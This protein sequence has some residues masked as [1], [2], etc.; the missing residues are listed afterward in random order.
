MIANRRYAFPGLLA[1]LGLLPLLAACPP[2]TSMGTARTVAPGDTQEWIS[3]GA[4][5]TTLVSGQPPGPVTRDEQWLPLFEAGLRFGIARGVDLGLRGGSGGGSIGPRFQLV[6][7]ETEDAGVDLLAEASLGWTG[8]YADHGGG[9]SGLFTGLA[10]P[11]G[12]NL[13]GG[14]QALAT[15]RIAVVS[16]SVLGNTVLSGGSLALALRLAGSAGR[17][18]YLVPECAVAGVSGGPSSFDGPLIQCALGV[19]GPWR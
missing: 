9:V 2:M 3:L 13:G 8:I 5:R 1:I 10:L 7:A 17:A 11:F 18:W 6:R 15:P 12:V 14:S 16:D 19:L 4:Y